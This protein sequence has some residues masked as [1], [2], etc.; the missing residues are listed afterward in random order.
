MRYTAGGRGCCFCAAC[1]P[2]TLLRNSVIQ[3][4]KPLRPTTLLSHSGWEI[5]MTDD[6]SRAAT[7]RDQQQVSQEWWREPGCCAAVMWVDDKLQWAEHQETTG[8]HIQP[9]KAKVT[10][11]SEQLADAKHQYLCISAVVSQSTRWSGGRVFVLGPV[12]CGF[13][14]KPGPIK[15]CGNGPHR[16]PS[17][18]SLFG[19]GLAGVRAPNISWP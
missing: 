11:K 19:V 15:D 7:T 3:Y 14:T 16:L 2:Q 9:Q 17:C 1:V 8:S 12:R 4:R 6:C 5:R 13:D 18:H 10:N